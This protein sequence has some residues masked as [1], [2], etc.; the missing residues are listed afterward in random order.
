MRFNCQKVLFELWPSQ[1]ISQS[2]VA[3]LL[4]FGSLRAE[5]AVK[6]LWRDR[7][8][9]NLSHMPG[10]VKRIGCKLVLLILVVEVGNIVVADTY[11]FVVLTSK[12]NT[13][14]S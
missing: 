2:I 13:G 3:N 1:I 9:A 7:S 11:R 6:L 10:F 8:Q 14:L 5:L 4:V 12:E